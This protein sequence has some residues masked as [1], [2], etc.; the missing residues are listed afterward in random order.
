M[1]DNL[2]AGWP[3]D[4]ISQIQHDAFDVFNGSQPLPNV[5]LL[6]A[7][8]NDALASHTSEDMINDLKAL[9][10]AVFVAAPDT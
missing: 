5:I 2:N 8:T 9:I 3:G 4:T 6:H 1:T 7:G 10:D